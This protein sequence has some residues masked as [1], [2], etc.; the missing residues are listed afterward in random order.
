MVKQLLFI[1]R[2]IFYVMRLD[3]DNKRLDSDA[4]KAA[5]QARVKQFFCKTSLLVFRNFRVLVAVL[6]TWWENFQRAE[7]MKKV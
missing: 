4:P 5:R 7:L 6:R 2:P 1:N 3:N